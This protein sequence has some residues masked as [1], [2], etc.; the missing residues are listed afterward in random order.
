MILF[1]SKINNNVFCVL[2]VIS[3]L[4]SGMRTT[5]YSVTVSVREVCCPSP[6]P[7]LV[8]GPHHKVILDMVHSVKSFYCVR[9][10][11]QCQVT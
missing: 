11:Y 9:Y 6:S 10:F 5:R 2:L 3:E 1:V 4:L 8:V 7:G